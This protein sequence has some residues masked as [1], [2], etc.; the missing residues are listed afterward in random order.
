MSAR[1]AEAMRSPE[2]PSGP[3]AHAERR[4]A[5]VVVHAKPPVLDPARGGD[6]A[7]RA[8]GLAGLDH[9]SKNEA[10]ALAGLPGG[11]HQMRVAIRRLRA[12]LSAFADR[13][14]EY[15][16]HWAAEELRWLSGALGPVRNLDVFE[17]VLLRPAERAASDPSGFEPLRDAIEPRRRAAH[18]DA[19]TAIRSDRYASLIAHLFRWFET[20]G[21]RRDSGGQPE[22]SVRETAASML[23][24]RWRVAKKRGRD[25]A[26]QSPLERH[27]LRIA[28]KKVRYTAEALS[29][30]YPS[31]HAAPLAAQLKRLQDELGHANDVRVAHEILGAVA[32]DADGGV[33]LAE[34]GR[35]MLAWHE[36]RLL[37][38]EPKMRKH[39]RE[40]FD[41]EPFW[42]S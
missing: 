7:L 9:L 34:A 21:R 25:F 10:A 36:Q 8:I 40:L 37:K 28:L 20:R 4:S 3:A 23:Q 22:P 42:R 24:R 1:L 14:P 39:L 32:A 41:M 33:A 15:Q 35:H 30:L 29:S 11:I 5:L 38:T 27:R 16:R 13:L 18:R 19:V 2:P 26:A 12:M 31:E 17:A 6:A